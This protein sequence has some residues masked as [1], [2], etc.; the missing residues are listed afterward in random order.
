[1]LFKFWC[2]DYVGSCRYTDTPTQP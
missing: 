1:M 2:V